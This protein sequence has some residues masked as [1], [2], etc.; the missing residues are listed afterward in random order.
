LAKR[1]LGGRTTSDDAERSFIVKLKT[2]CG[3][4]FTSKIEAGGLLRT[5]TRPSFCSD[6]AS[7]HACQTVKAFTLK[8]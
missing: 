1:L 2:E 4:Q 6:E 5:I 3:Y 7:P 8:V